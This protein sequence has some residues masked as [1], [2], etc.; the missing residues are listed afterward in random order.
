MVGCIRSELFG[1]DSS[2]LNYPSSFD[3]AQMLT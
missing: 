2:Q 3:L 1:N